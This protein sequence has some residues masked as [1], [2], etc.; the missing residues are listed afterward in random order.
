MLRDVLTTAMK[1]AMRNKDARRLTTVRLILAAIKDRDIA[2]RG[3]G[4]SERI[5][6]AAIAELLAKMIKQRQDSIT[7]Y[8]QGGR[9][10]LAEQ[11]QA[12]IDIIRDFLPPQLSEADVADAA[13]NAIAE[14]EAQGLKDMGR[15]MAVLKERYAGQM[16]FSKASAVVR[17]ILA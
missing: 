17:Q 11:E 2:S 5:D 9:V 1:D 14:L 13:K 10:D 6:D 3:D 16:D 8:Q 15:V 4:G 12:E 7:A